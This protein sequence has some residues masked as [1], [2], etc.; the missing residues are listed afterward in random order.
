MFPGTLISAFSNTESPPPR[1]S[2]MNYIWICEEDH[3]AVPQA[4]SCYVPLYKFDRAYKN[5]RKYPDTDFIIWM[6]YERLDDSS[7]FFFESHFYLNASDNT[8]VRDLNELESYSN[9]ALFKPEEEYNIFQQADYARLLVLQ[10]CFENANYDDV[11]YSDLDVKNVRVESARVAN[12]LAQF[13]MVFPEPLGGN[14]GGIEN[15]YMGFRR[16]QGESFLQDTLIPFTRDR[17]KDEENG[18]GAFIDAIDTWMAAQDKAL[19]LTHQKLC[20]L[21]LAPPMGYKMPVPK[22]YARMGFDFE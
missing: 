18:F 19:R 1:S 17:I 10:D 11:F 3:S 2:V 4:G 20:L 5:A 13:G 14:K 21:A 16:G 22:R 6:D 8:Q 9:D 12:R 7:R 15:S